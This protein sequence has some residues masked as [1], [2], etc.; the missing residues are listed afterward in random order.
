MDGE[1]VGGI[2]ISAVL[3]TSLAICVVGALVY[4]CRRHGCR[5]CTG[6]EDSRTST[7]SAAA[8][9]LEPCRPRTGLSIVPPAH[10]S[11]RGGVASALA[12][13]FASARAIRPATPSAMIAAA[14]GAVARVTPLRRSPR[15][16]FQ[17]N[18]RRDARGNVVAHADVEVA[19]EAERPLPATVGI[20]RGP[21]ARAALAA[22]AAGGVDAVWACVRTVPLPHASG[23]VESFGDVEAAQWLAPVR[24]CVDAVWEPLVTEVERRIAA[25]G[26]GGLWDQLTTA[27]LVEQLLAAAGERAAAVREATAALLA[28]AAA[29]WGR[30]R[31]L[32]AS[33][34]PGAAAAEASFESGPLC[35]LLGLLG[36]TLCRTV[37]VEEPHSVR[38]CVLP[39]ETCRATLGLEGGAL[40]AL[41]DGR[42]K[43]LLVYIAMVQRGDARLKL[44]VGRAA[45]LWEALPQWI[46]SPFAQPGGAYH[47]VKLFPRFHAEAGEGHGPRKELFAAMG[48]QLLHG[49]AVSVAVTAGGAQAGGAQAGGGGIRVVEPALL[50]YVPASRQHWFEPVRARTKLHEELCRFAG[51]LMGQSMCNRAPLASTSCPTLLFRCLLAPDG[52]TPPSLAILQEFDPDASRNLDGVRSLPPAAF[53]ALCE[54]DDLEP[55]TTSRDGYVAAAAARL[56]YGGVAWQLAALVR[57]FREAVPPDVLEGVRLTP[58]QLATAVCGT[59]DGGSA[60]DFCIRDTFRLVRGNLEGSEPLADCLWRVLEGW[61]GADKRRFVKFVTGSDRLP[62]PGS[63]VITV[64]LAHAEIG[65]APKVTLGTLPQAHTCDNLVRVPKPLDPPLL[66]LDP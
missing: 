14:S 53:T 9:Q 35:R 16:H 31:I 52:Q 19:V 57:G 54:L 13:I 51:W 17:L 33:A 23:D 61:G 42:C 39:W 12:S 58:N 63:E 15:R 37:G 50:P 44:S 55:T 21:A 34:S 7:R 20:E 26:S 40:C 56:L 46:D 1:D 24:A 6:F 25:S 48:T 65:T 4:C 32:S 8:A 47:S 22:A 18:E 41:L 64:Q 66:T 2:I 43:G 11:V 49:S 3:G 28:T 59:A 5:C 27:E 38:R 60:A 30:Q 10:R 29:L 36:I 45:A 62:A